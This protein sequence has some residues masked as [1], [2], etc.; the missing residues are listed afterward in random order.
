MKI[1]MIKYVFLKTGTAAVL[2]FTALSLLTGCKKYLDVK[3]NQSYAV[4]AKV[5][6]FQALLDYYPTMNTND[7]GS[8]EVSAGDYY[9]DST[10]Y[11][12]LSSQ[13]D[14]D[15]YTWQK[16][17]LYDPGYNDWSNAY[18][19]VYV[20]NEVLDGLQK[21]PAADGLENVRGQALVFRAKAFL[22]IAAIWSLAYDNT[23]ASTDLGIPLRLSSDFNLPSVRSSV[24]ETYRRILADLKQA[25]PL[26][27]VKQLTADRPSRAAAYGLLAR[28]CLFMRDYPNAGR[29]ADSCLQLNNHLLDFKT[30]DPAPT[31]PIPR[32]N[33]EIDFET[34]I[35]PLSPIGNRRAK[36]D[37]LLY[38]SYADGD[39][40]KILFFRKNADGTHAFRGS[41]E[42]SS[43]LFSGIATDEMYLARA[44]AMARQG[45][46]AAALADLNTLLKT[47]WDDTFQPLSAASAH[48]ALK[49]VLTERRKELLM[50]GLRWMDLKRLN[51]EGAAITLTRMVNGRVYTLPPND[52]RYA[53]PLPDD[54]IALSG[55]PQNPR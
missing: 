29:Y 39:L 38:Q 10:I 1:K 44:E 18:N 9:L 15:M 19:V 3:T 24:A 21:L 28:T 13:K 52:L 31:Y 8:G 5:S 32:F 23:S 2:V 26:L 6:D 4:P 45:N 12:G 25:V 54:I 42:A 34:D 17:N 53:L 36:I 22:Q 37:P 43:L 46:T 20:A 47:R 27:P 48:D 40:R 41:Y 35:P 33:A 7:P 16:Y 14:K 49:L 55:M 51:K 30:L 11:N 50:R